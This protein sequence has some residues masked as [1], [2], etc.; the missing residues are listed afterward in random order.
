M[1]WPISSRAELSLPDASGLEEFLL[2]CN[3]R[4]D[5][6]LPLEDTPSRN[7]QGMSSTGMTN[8]PRLF[9]QEQI[10]QIVEPQYLHL[11]STPEHEHVGSPHPQTRPI[12]ST[13]SDLSADLQR[14]LRRM[15]LAASDCS[16]D[17]YRPRTI[18][19]RPRKSSASKRRVTPRS[20][21]HARELELNRKAA[22]KC[23]NRQKAFVEHL[24]ERC[25]EEQEKMR[26]QTSL[27]HAL[28]DEVV[29]LRNEVMRQSLCECHFLVDSGT[30][31]LS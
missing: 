9:S 12:D 14:T 4:P 18:Q 1:A 6:G 27:V 22:A 3:A 23:R 10:P 11:V 28:H 20:E 24:E 19:A 15:Y 17:S 31:V 25:R 30:S 26:I 2:L 13:D 29:A 21:K 16:N 5:D 7:E 8:S